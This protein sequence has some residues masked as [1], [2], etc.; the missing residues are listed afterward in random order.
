[1]TLARPSHPTHGRD[2]ADPR[3]EA[4]FSVLELLV[5]L[6]L[7]ALIL[8]ALPTTLQMG[9]RAWS[10][11]E[12]LDRSATVAVVATFVR[13]RVAQ[14]MPVQQRGDGGA[15]AV[16]FNGRG[17]GLSF[18]APALDGPTG[19]GLFVFEIALTAA[20][21]GHGRLVLRWRPYSP[22]A[23]GG[24]APAADE[25]SL[26]EDVTAFGVRYFGSSPSGGGRDWFDS[27]QGRNALPELVEV[28]LETSRDA[29]A[30]R[31]PMVIELQLRR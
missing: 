2:C 14:A 28:R 24:K 9:K 21:H 30:A 25:R 19:Q 5:S 11:A 4:G 12:A 17:D 6:A 3:D 20:A 29:G 22:G 23:D 10:T 31:M 1:M 8:T 26:I 15:S 16:A 13:E 7:L 27:W 18:V